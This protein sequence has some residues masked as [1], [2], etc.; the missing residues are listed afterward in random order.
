MAFLVVW[1]GSRVIRAGAQWHS[2][3]EPD[4]GSGWG[5]NFLSCSTRGTDQS[6]A[7]ASRLCPE[8]EFRR[9][10]CQQDGGKGGPRSCLLPPSHPGPKPMI[11]QLSIDECSSGR[12]PECRW[13]AAATQWSIGTGDDSRGK[14]RSHFS[15]VTPSPRPAQPSTK[16]NPLCCQFL[17]GEKG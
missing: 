12:T 6:L 11:Y 7:W 4:K 13:Q 10:R 15:C 5:V 9:Q 14:G 8:E 1:P 2:V 17:H 3:W 16:K